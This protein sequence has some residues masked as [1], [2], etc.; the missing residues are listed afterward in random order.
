MKHHI[1]FLV[2][3]ILSNKVFSNNSNGSF[4]VEANLQQEYDVFLLIGQSNMAGRGALVEGDYSPIEGVFLL[5]S[6]NTI[7][8]A[9]NPLNKYSSIRKDLSLQQMCPGYGFSKKIYAATGRKVLLVVNARGGST[10]E[11]WAKDNPNKNY[12]SE[13]VRRA[14][15]AM[16]FGRLVAI[17]WHQGEGNS[18]NPQDY[19]TNLSVFVNNL[20]TDLEAQN[21][22]FV[23]GEIANWWNPQAS[24]FNPVI[25]EISKYIPYSDYI[26]VEGT[27]SATNESDPHFNR[28]GQIIIGERY[29]QKVLFMCYR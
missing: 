10:I 5:T 25:R 18:D 14:K 11:E 28:E 3:L 21:V 26:S 13:A 29:A 7:E 17:L 24:K 6:D 9:S 8:P 4:S 19:L 2:I 16:K 22:P 20:R 1:L 12:Y 27:S 15:E 23:A